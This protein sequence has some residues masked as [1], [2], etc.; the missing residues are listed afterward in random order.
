MTSG[1]EFHVSV[2]IPTYKR[3]DGLFRAI[4]SVFRQEKLSELKAELVVVDNDPAGSAFPVTEQLTE[5]PL[6]VRYVHAREPGVANAR[7]AAV[8][9]VRS[10]LIAFL[11]DDQ[12]APGDWLTMLVDAHTRYRAA[13]T[14]GPVTTALP[15]TV[16]EHAH[17]LNDFFS[18]KGPEA[19]GVIDH[20]YGCG[21]SLID[22][23]QMPDFT[24]LFDSQT[25]ETGGEDD[26]LFSQLKRLGKTF[27]WA[28]DA[29][30]YEHV[31][32]SRATLRYTLRR[33]FAYGQ[34][35]STLCL[36]KSPPDIPGLI[37][38][39]IIGSGQ[40]LI[41]GGVS[42]LARLAGRSDRAFWYDRAVRGLGKVLWFGPFEFR[43]YGANASH[44]A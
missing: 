15:D 31:P 2:V 34:G 41:Y 40:A 3:P 32:E 5:T 16:S 12:S 22:L 13:V 17:Y 18:R 43:F 26:F 27:A 9:A 10:P 37:Y 19:S 35:P 29:P 23:S 14:F 44:A 36:K 24:P 38:W 28:K 42:L 30:V 7:N 11:D 21:N 25:N 39:T 20:Y 1:D 6:P 33:A 4:E 8:A